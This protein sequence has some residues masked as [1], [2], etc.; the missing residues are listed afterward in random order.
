MGVGKGGRGAAIAARRM[1]RRAYAGLGEAVPYGR[2]HGGRVP[3]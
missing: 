3:R 2:G 1:F